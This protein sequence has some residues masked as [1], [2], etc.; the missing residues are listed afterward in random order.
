MLLL[1][2]LLYGLPIYL[3]FGYFRL[4]PLTR[5]WKICLPVPP[6]V[7][8]LFA[9]YALGHYT[10]M[11]HSAYLQAPIVQIAAQT[12]GLVTEVL[13]EDNEDVQPGQALFQVDPR[14]WELQARQA[15]ARLW[16]IQ[17]RGLESWAMLYATNQSL[18]VAESRLQMAN[19]D[20]TRADAERL[21]KLA[22]VEKLE[23]QVRLAD[24]EV[25][26]A[27]TLVDERAIS[28]QEFEE[29]LRNQSVQRAGLI[30]ATQAV[31]QSETSIA[32]ARSQVIAAEAACRETR[33]QLLK[34]L[35]SID[36]QLALT[37][38]LAESV[39][40]PMRG[41]ENVPQTS[42]NND[43][44]ADWPVFIDKNTLRQQLREAEKIQPKL[45][46]R[47]AT[48]IQAE[49][50]WKQAEYQLEQCLVQA[51]SAGTV[52]N[53]QL[54][55]GTT[56][57]SG[58]PVMTLMDKSSWVLVI[59]I[60]EN[61]LSR[62]KPGDEVLFALRNQPLQFRR[63]QVRNI[64]PGV[65]A[66][67]AVPSG[68]LPDT[69]SRLGRQF[70]TPENAQQFQVIVDISVTESELPRLT[71]ATG[72]AVIL[73]GGGLAGINTLATLLLTI[74]TSLDFFYPK[75]SLL[76]W[77][78]LAAGLALVFALRVSARQSDTPR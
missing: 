10:P 18:R 43:P 59:P 12:P 69:E 2:V 58:K 72:H 76:V 11:S 54:T 32:T 71:G 61:G 77:L 46:G 33:A 41:V 68:A 66:G 73:A 39:E 21:S 17:E 64:I 15:E 63:G 6:V 56:V 36:P 28:P 30:E 7:C 23:A 60:P 37:L 13:V 5:F 62:V 65:I 35:A 8:L 49:N 38:A 55:A 31:I 52:V 19:L 74:S 40:E 75:P 78:A 50:A 57:G 67:Q 48:V 34:S 47:L 24:A 22:N 20:V 4:L 70:D 3:V 44:H 9:W 29:K 42:P 26:R 27:Q 53:L 1:I 25:T 14:P 51:P 45:A 16:E